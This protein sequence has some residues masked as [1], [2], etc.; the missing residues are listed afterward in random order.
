MLHFEIQIPIDLKAIDGN[1]EYFVKKLIRVH[2]GLAR[3]ENLHVTGYKTL[4]SSLGKKW[5]FKRTMSA[6][7][8]PYNKHGKI[9]ISYLS[10]SLSCGSCCKVTILSSIV[11]P[12]Q[13]STSDRVQ[14]LC[15]EG[16]ALVMRSVRFES[17]SVL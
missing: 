4:F 15:F 7:S 8:N 17:D 16:K 5:P 12:I 11:F 1:A 3:A 6:P 2:E 10:I 9:F 13:T 14:L